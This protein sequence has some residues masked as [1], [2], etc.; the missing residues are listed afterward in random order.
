MIFSGDYYLYFA[1]IAS[2]TAV[3]GVRNIRIYADGATSDSGQ[4]GQKLK[5][6]R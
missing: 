3:E 1:I 2:V 6:R 4:M 5:D